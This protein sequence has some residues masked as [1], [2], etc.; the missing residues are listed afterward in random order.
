MMSTGDK[1]KKYKSR[2]P[3]TDE[4]LLRQIRKKKYRQ[5]N[6]KN[7]L[8]HKARSPVVYYPQP[9][10]CIAKHHQKK[11]RQRGIH[12]KNKIFQFQNSLVYCVSYYHANLKYIVLS[13]ISDLTVCLF[14]KIKNTSGSDS[15]SVFRCDR[16]AVFIK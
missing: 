5:S 1:T 4:I 14:D 12:T 11:N 13:D 2:I 15:M 7:E 8:I 6:L 10:E 9:S 16:M 3:G